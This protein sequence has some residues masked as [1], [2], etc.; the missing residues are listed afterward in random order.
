MQHPNDQSTPCALC[1]E[2]PATEEY[3]RKGHTEFVCTAC[4]DR[5]TVQ[6][7]LEGKLL[8]ILAL[9][10][11]ERYDEALACLDTILASNR[12]RDH[13]GWLANSV[14]HHRALI[15]FEAGRYEEAERTYNEWAQLGFIDLWR[16]QMHAS[17]LAQTLEALGRDEEAL[18]VLEDVLT[19]QDPKDVP[20]AF[21]ILTEVVRLSD[22]LARPVD[23]TWLAVAK[24]AAEAYGVEV[25]ARDSPRE[26]ILALA[27]LTRGEQPKRPGH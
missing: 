1:G 25:P 24:A 19:Y 18:A 6:D 12:H 2:M 7:A 14:A 17:G 3:K 11:S 8:D 4:F 10:R 16:R 23:S 26:T 5:W 20:L 27:E 22:K 9:E 13:D 21:M 15:F